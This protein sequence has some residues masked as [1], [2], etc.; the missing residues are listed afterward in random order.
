MWVACAHLEI[1]RP[2]MHGASSRNAWNAAALARR[3]SVSRY[4]SLCQNFCPRNLEL[5]RR[6]SKV[7]VV[8]GNCCGAPIRIKN[9][10]D[11]V[12]FLLT[13]TLLM[14]VWQLSWIKHVWLGNMQ[15]ILEPPILVHSA[16][17][18][19]RPN[20]AYTHL[21]GS[22]CQWTWCPHPHSPT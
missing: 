20:V 15:H 12:R 4:F 18:F 19:A 13:P 22:S 2:E 11:W 10:I 9:C 17:R 1:C 5:L 21:E 8:W 7:N 16:L 6:S 14:A 3:R